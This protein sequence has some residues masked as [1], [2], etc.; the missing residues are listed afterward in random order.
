MGVHGPSLTPQECGGVL[1]QSCNPRVGARALSSTRPCR[2]AGQGWMDTQEGGRGDTLLGPWE[3]GKREGRLLEPKG[4]FGSPPN[5]PTA[6]PAIPKFIHQG[7]PTRTQ[8]RP[9][10][11]LG[12]WGNRP[13]E[14]SLI[15]PFRQVW[16][17]SRGQLLEVQGN[18]DHDL[19]WR[20][21]SS[22]EQLMLL[23][24]AGHRAGLHPSRKAWSP[25]HTTTPPA[26]AV[27]GIRIVRPLGS[28]EPPHY[29]PPSTWK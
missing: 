5:Y 12:S 7:S 1:G 10:S 24:Q 29:L 15:T 18:G 14:G 26:A 17:L 16:P 20:S 9:A 28:G 4:P 25:S 8:P 11:P 13:E 19:V 21:P 22:L 23:P 3:F 2:G 27:G 6:T